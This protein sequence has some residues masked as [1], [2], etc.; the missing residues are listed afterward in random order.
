MQ[1]PWPDTMMVS[2]PSAPWAM[3]ASRSRRTAS[4]IS[5][6]VPSVRL[7]PLAWAKAGPSGT[8]VTSAASL[9]GPN[10]PTVSTSGTPTPARWA[11]KVRY[12]SCSTCCRRSMMRVGPESRYT[13]NRH[14]LA[15]TPA[16]D[17]SR[18]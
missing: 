3:P 14:S 2:P 1:T 9:L 18:P 10:R 17:A 16:S 11:I 13:P 8:L 15:S 6:K 5:S 4:K 12:A 7:A